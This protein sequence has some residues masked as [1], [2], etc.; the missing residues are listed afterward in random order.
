MERFRAKFLAGTSFEDANT[1]AMLKSFPFQL[2]CFPNFISDVSLVDTLRQEILH[3]LHQQSTQEPGE[4]QPIMQF[5]HRKNDLHDFFQSMDL[6]GLCYD[7]LHSTTQNEIE[8]TKESVN[9]CI[10][11]G[12]GH[13]IDCSAIQTAVKLFAPHHSKPSCVMRLLGELTGYAINHQQMDI[14][15]QVYL[16]GS[17]LLCHDD[18]LEGRLIAWILY[19]LDE[20]PLLGGSLQ[21]FESEP[22][23]GC[24][25]PTKVVDHVSPQ[26]NMLVFFPVSERSFH[27]VEE[28]FKGTR[29]SIAGWFYATDKTTINQ[30]RAIYERI[31]EGYDNKRDPTDITTSSI[32]TFEKWSTFSAL[33]LFPI[34]PFYGNPGIG[35]SIV[36]VLH[37]ENVVSLQAFFKESPPTYSHLT[38]ANQWRLVGPP[39]HR[40]YY[41][42][43][44]SPY[45]DLLV[46]SV[47]S[48]YHSINS[49]C[50]VVLS[51]HVYQFGPGSYQVIHDDFPSGMEQALDL[52][53]FI[54][55]ISSS[56][57]SIAS[58]SLIKYG[59]LVK[60]QPK[61]G[62]HINNKKASSSRMLKANA[63]IQNRTS[64]KPKTGAKKPI[65]EVIEIDPT[66]ANTL[67]V[68]TVNGDTQI[69][70]DYLKATTTPFLMVAIRLTTTTTVG[71]N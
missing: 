33:Q 41:E 35:S 6:K 36:S 59:S 13:P 23:R 46:A 19:L 66:V 61:K 68:V 52:L 69:S 71:P 39:N 51:S 24:L 22:M 18:A 48:G 12:N 30:E 26:R 60:Q 10:L 58:K 64:Y 4:S 34:N 3:A 28:T 45:V 43:V 57:D 25:Y 53:F 15:A 32:S 16:P 55:C 40:H 20:E 65:E 17:F 7:P 37:R 63:T 8:K 54:P 38:N 47:V 11:I 9:K 2:A 44:E 31:T 56:S 14:A 67:Y 49:K 62:K 27:A 5:F 21:L 29:V 42:C 50:W 1:G 70:V